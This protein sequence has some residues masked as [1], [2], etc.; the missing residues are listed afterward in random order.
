VIIISRRS[1]GEIVANIPPH[2]LIRLQSF[3]FFVEILLWLLFVSKLLPVQMTFE[4]R[5]LDI[6]AGISAPLVAFFAFR[7]RISRAGLIIWNVVCIGLL[8][9]IV[10][11]A[12]L[13]TPSPW[14]VFSNE[15]ANY[16]VTYFPISWLPGL[17][18]PLAYYL[19]SL[20]LKQLIRKPLDA[21]MAH[22]HKK[23]GYKS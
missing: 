4:G 14:R 5:N 8:L 23:S 3:R 22:E 9:N 1:V 20:S 6:L 2:R 21:G 10:I 13:S 16:I 18:V 19:H 11:I 12:V 17:L 7:G 15:P